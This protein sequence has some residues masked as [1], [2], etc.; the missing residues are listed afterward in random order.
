MVESLIAFSISGKRAGREAPPFFRAGL[1]PIG[2]LVVLVG[3]MTVCSTASA[4]R[5]AP[6]DPHSAYT[7]W[8]NKYKPASGAAPDNSSRLPINKSG[9]LSPA[10]DVFWRAA[11]MTET[12]GRGQFASDG[13]PL[14]GSSD[15]KRY[16]GSIISIGASQARY[17]ID[18]YGEAKPYNSYLGSTSWSLE[19]YLWDPT[20]NT[21][22]G[23]GYYSKQ[24]QAAGNNPCLAVAAYNGGLGGMRRYRDAGYKPVDNVT[25]MI[26]THVSKFTSFA[27]KIAGPHAAEVNKILETSPGCSGSMD[28]IDPAPKS[29]TMG[30]NLDIYVP[31]F[32]DPRAAQML[33]DGY[34]RVQK[35]RDETF[36][37]LFRTVKTHPSSGGTSNGGDTRDGGDGGAGGGGSPVVSDSMDQLGSCVS[38]SW[39]NLK[40]S[41][42]TMDEI[43]RAAERQVIQ[44]ACSAAREKINEA[45]SPLTGSFYF[46]PRIPGVPPA[47]GSSH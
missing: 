11:L 21:A 26:H 10:Y 28:D 29:S 32:C 39:P 18:V 17:D 5:L 8:V 31:G 30:E 2:L 7:A 3:A 20:Y 41:Y 45:K 46:N 23:Y 1:R 13:T 6:K 34:E 35:D 43:I 40:I 19:R 22:I 24:M 42:P 25:T 12:S 9:G 16:G 36:E 4:Q 14:K 15:G 33:R 44:K 38:L 27:R 37:P 47:G